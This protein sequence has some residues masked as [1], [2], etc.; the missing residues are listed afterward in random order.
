M[1][2]LR[3]PKADT[4]G[5]A[6]NTTMFVPSG[7]GQ[8]GGAQGGEALE[9][10]EGE[11]LQKTGEDTSGAE[12]EKTGETA[13][14]EET[15]GEVKF[16]DFFKVQGTERDNLE[17]ESK[18]TTTTDK[19]STEKPVAATTPDKP[20]ATKLQVTNEGRDY[21]GLPEADIPIFKRMGNDAFAKFKP[22]YL[23]H[24]QLK[25][26]VKQ[27]DAKIAEL[28]KGVPVLPDYYFEHPQGFL[29]DP[30]YAQ[31]EAN[32]DLAGKIV[33]HWSLQLAKIRR[34]EQWQDLT[35]DPKTGKLLVDKPQAA[36]A[37]AE[38]AV[39]Q[40]LMSTQ[41][42]L[43]EQR[44]KLNNI[45]QTFS[46]RHKSDLDMLKEGE[47]KYFPDF[48]KPDHPTANIQKEVLKA[49]PPSFRSSPLASV[50]AKTAAANAILRAEIAELKKL[51][52]AKSAGGNGKGKQP[53][54]SQVGSTASGGAAKHEVT[55]KDFQEVLS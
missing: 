15:T 30:T 20:V 25:E 32:T 37:E 35:E 33:Q 5:G 6:I 21:S 44:Q 12:L 34:G 11:E 48:D 50:L 42:Q 38:A 18:Q 51:Q 3:D 16:D 9:E 13:T 4:G 47:A 19:K 46:A 49:L 17:D 31:E 26:T 29:L 40:Y 24:T 43:M 14:G 8:T 39:G 55:F 10:E 45:T 2:I 53:T 27:K 23:E 7:D 41:Q 54:K 52:G 22:I 36:T 28:Q 1:L